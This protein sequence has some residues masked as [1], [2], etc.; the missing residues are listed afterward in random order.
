MFS[1]VK[2]FYGVQT[3][4]HHTNFFVN[5]DNLQTYIY[6]PLV[7]SLSNLACEGRGG[8]A[9]GG[10]GGWLVIQLLLGGQISKTGSDQ[11][12]GALSSSVGGLC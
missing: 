4:P 9:E 8:G 11:F 6:A 1:I 7:I 10:G 3:C 5:F 12:Y 2:K